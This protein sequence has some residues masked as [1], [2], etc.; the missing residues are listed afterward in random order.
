[1][2]PVHGCS[3]SGAFNVISQVKDAVALMYSPQGCSYLSFNTHLNR[4]PNSDPQYTPNLLCTNMN[5]TDAIFGGVKHLEETLL[6][7]Q[8]RFPAYPIFLITSCPAGIIGDDVDAVIT[9][10]TTE[11]QKILHVPSDGVL[12]GDFYAG[13]FKAYQTVAEHFIDDNVSPEADTVNLIGE[14]NLSTTADQNFTSIS[15][16]LSDLGLK[17]N[18]RFIRQTSLEEIK[19]FKK[20]KINIPIINQSTITALTDY[21]DTRFGT[22]T[23]NPPIPIAFNQTAEFTR[24]VARCFDKEAAAE[25]LIENAKVTHEQEIASLRMYFAGKKAS[26]YNSYG[27]NIDWLVSTLADLGVEV[28]NISSTE[29]SYTTER[30]VPLKPQTYTSITQLQSTKQLD[31]LDFMLTNGPAQIDTKIPCESF[32]ILPLYGFNSGLNYAKQLCTKL[33]IPFTERWRKDEK[34]FHSFN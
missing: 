18:C 28:F 34:L 20:A 13:M 30:A 29:L 15:Q 24:A 19:N 31:Q 4:V 26:I 8:K 7:T 2:E 16:I 6:Y 27:C 14:Q 5:E 3:L 10:L 25:R 21:L 12:G 11:K 17:I 32:P 1:R 33:K 22:K 9:R 23:I